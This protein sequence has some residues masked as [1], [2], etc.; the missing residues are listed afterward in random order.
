MERSKSKLYF[1]TIRNQFVIYMLTSTAL[2]LIIAMFAVQWVQQS[3][4][5]AVLPAEE[6][7]MTALD[8]IP[9]LDTVPATSLVAAV[10]STPAEKLQ[11]QAAQ[12][13]I[14][15]KQD[16][17]DLVGGRYLILIVGLILLQL[18]GS[19]FW[20]DRYLVK[21]INL[22]LKKIDHLVD[23]DYSIEAVAD[24]NHEMTHLNHQLY[25]LSET[26]K[27]S[28]AFKSEE[29]DRRKALIAGMSH[30]LRTP[31]TNICGYTET[32]M[33]EE[34]LDAQHQSWLEIIMRNAQEANGL[35]TNLLDINRFDMKSYPVHI[36]ELDVAETI[37]EALVDVRVSLTSNDQKVVIED[38]PSHMNFYTDRLLF[39]RLVKNIIANFIEH[40][41]N[42]TCLNVSFDYDA[43]SDVGTFTFKDNGKGVEIEEVPR[44]TELFYTSDPSR[45]M[46]SRSGLGLYNCKQ[47][48][49][50]LGADMSIRSRIGEGFE[51]CIRLK[52]PEV[53][54]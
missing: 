51:I 20:I 7:F 13:I 8:S 35:I 27:R 15:I 48:T 43:G 49:D 53:I 46:K 12:G 23:M 30:D 39:K 24:S 44:L 25:V 38:I 29:M 42:G 40:A 45:T 19:I 41:G 4:T 9:A 50:I 11:L 31:L 54:S 6:I 32:L 16:F 36:Q 26:L 47:I 21:P 10:E 52:N 1:S 37:H 18:L 5:L 33:A 17:S 22:A 28:D 2:V 3:S 14:K 34:N